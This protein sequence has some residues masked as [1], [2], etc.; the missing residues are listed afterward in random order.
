V[1]LEIGWPAATPPQILFPRQVHVWAWSLDR[2]QEDPGREVALLDPGELARFGRFH[3][4]RDRF[5]FAWAH[6]KMRRILGSYL[7]QPAES[8]RFVTNAFDK[9][10]LSAVE[11]A[12]PLRF[13]LSHTQGI[14]VLA[15]SLDLE[16]GVDVEA[17]RPIEREIAK[18][19]FS[20]AEVKEL[21]EMQGDAWLGGFYRC[22]TRKEAILKAEGAGLSLPL[23]GFDVS[24]GPNAPA[25]LLC[26]RPPLKFRHPWQLHDLCPAPSTAAAL[27]TAGA[28]AGVVCFRLEQ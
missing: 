16:L 22:W 9:P 25:E 3:F 11:T 2:P 10:E 6:G 24:L 27:A 5:R 17:I 21:D 18:S 8:L 12:L 14:A 26:A 19:Y 20:V 28:T 15:L 13:N 23:D 1:S 4:D 7:Q